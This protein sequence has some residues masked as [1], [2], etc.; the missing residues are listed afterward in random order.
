MFALVVMLFLLAML[1]VLF[2]GRLAEVLKKRSGKRTGRQKSLSHKGR[3]AETARD[4]AKQPKRR[5]GARG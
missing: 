1:I 4:D 3:T 5:E 2:V